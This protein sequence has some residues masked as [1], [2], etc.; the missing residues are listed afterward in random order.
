[1]PAFKVMTTLKVGPSKPGNAG[2]TIVCVPY[3]CAGNAHQHDGAHTAGTC[4]I[5]QATLRCQSTCTWQHA[6]VKHRPAF[7]QCMQVPAQYMII[8]MRCLAH[9]AWS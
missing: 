1:M 4:G 8:Q 6:S 2:P 5:L 9:G 3:T 7:L